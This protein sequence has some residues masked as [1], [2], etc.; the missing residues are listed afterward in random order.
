MMAEKRRLICPLL[1]A[2]VLAAGPAVGVAQTTDADGNPPESSTSK[3]MRVVEDAGDSIALEIASK[4]YVRLQEEGPTVW[5][6]G[7]AHVAE[8]SFFE[9]VGAL[10]DDCDVVLYESVGPPGSGGA[11]GE[12][13]AQ[14]RAS[15]KTAMQFVMGL[16]EW[17]HVRRQRYPD[18]LDELARFAAREDPRLGRWVQAAMIDAWGSPLRYQPRET[19][20]AAP[21]FEL[22]SL[23]ADGKLGGDDAAAD[24]RLIEKQRPGAAGIAK[25]DALQ[26]ELAKALG[27]AFQ[28][29]SLRY[30]EPNWRGSD[31]AADQLER[32]LKK[33]GIDFAPIEGTL[34]GSSITAKFIKFALRFMSMLDRFLEGGITDTVKVA[35]IDM[36]GDERVV[37]QSL[38]QL[39]PGFAEVIV[40]QRNQIAIDDL[41]AIIENEPNV[42][43][44]AILYGAAHMRDLAER[45][46]DQLGYQPADERWLT[47][48]EV[49]MADSV[50]PAAELNRMRRLLKDAMRAQMAAE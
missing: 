45:L 23:G 7:V 36:L 48:L 49:N 50:V 3:F 21:G 41:R 27:L 5:L 31:M 6:V 34:A 10:L 11:G 37:E 14:R 30:D 8:A 9:A 32:A 40:G 24:I 25:D 17:H 26:G 42:N 22:V 33:R 15:T 1:A 28:I 44:V 20:D 13:P 39:G 2:G 43:S 18:D 47:G 19:E 46:T 38:A 4:R 29:D 12:T 16:I 35:M